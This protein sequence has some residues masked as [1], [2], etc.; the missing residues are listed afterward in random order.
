MIRKDGAP[1]EEK[2]FQLFAISQRW[3]GRAQKCLGGVGG[4]QVVT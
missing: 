3:C 1:S 4:T 2:V